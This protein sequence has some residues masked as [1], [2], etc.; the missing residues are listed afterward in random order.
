MPLYLYW[1]DDDFA[2]NKAVAALKAKTLDPDWASFN[3][4]RINADQPEGALAALTQAMTPP[5]GLGQRL[6]WLAEP[7]FLQQASEAIS[8]E[9]ERSLPQLLDSSALLIT[10]QK[11]PNGRLKSTKLLQKHAEEKEFSAIPPWKTDQITDQVRQAAKEVGVKLTRASGEF[12]VEAVGNNSRQLY[13]ELEK[14]RLFGNGPGGD[15]SE[16]LDLETVAG[17][18]TTSTQ[19]SLQLASAIR[20]GDTGK[21]LELVADL[22]G[23]NEP[24]LRIVATL[25]GQFRTWLW[26]RVMTEAG[27]RDEKAIAQAAGV[28]NPKR[29]YFLRQEINGLSQPQLLQ[30]MPLLLSLESEIKLGREP[31]ATLQTKVIELCQV[32]RGRR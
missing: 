10:S 16:P 22:L 29:I 5:F 9:L 31:Q 15:R 21:A 11:K 25:V 20:M 17:L 24:A 19:S 12:L 27:E 23:R 6:I 3:F 7:P 2:L 30:A 4:E 13:N 26:V 32:C 1:G 8:Q 28:G 18:V 14:L